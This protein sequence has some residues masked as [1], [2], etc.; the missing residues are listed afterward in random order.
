MQQRKGALPVTRFL[1]LLLPPLVTALSCARV[2]TGP[3]VERP[4]PQPVPAPVDR[5]TAPLE[6]NFDSA[7]HDYRI[8]SRTSIT[9][10]SDPNSTPIDSIIV[11]AEVSLGYELDSGGSLTVTG[12]V[13]RL[14]IATGL[15]TARTRTDSAIN[16]SISWKWE[17]DSTVV[18]AGGV[19]AD[20]VACDR[21]EDT[22]RELLLS[23]LPSLPARVA[24]A[25]RWRTAT[26]YSSCRGG[27]V[28]QVASSG[29]VQPV[30]F[31]QARQT[32]R[33]SLQSQGNI[34]V[35][36][37]GSQGATTVTVR[38]TGSTHATLE[39]D[40]RGTGLVNG[41]SRTNLSVEFD[42][43][44]RTDRFTQNTVRRVDLVR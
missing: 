31:P 19:R 3:T 6:L 33:L 44:Y 4:T 24:N 35:H 37:S 14:T 27:V 2:G 8:E 29:S 9:S 7:R 40:L 42:L 32:G 41:S 20:T 12:I 22:A 10:Q 25:D 1:L 13:Q 30:D 28:L 15:G 18:L 43:G 21:L 36:G 17:G 5:G 16:T 11:L 26:S 34:T 39:L 23:M 38:G